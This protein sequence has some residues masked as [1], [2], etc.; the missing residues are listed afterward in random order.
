[1]GDLY[2]LWGLRRGLDIHQLKRPF[3]LG[4]LDLRLF[5]DLFQLLFQ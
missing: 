4:L 1:V 3:G 5:L 2:I